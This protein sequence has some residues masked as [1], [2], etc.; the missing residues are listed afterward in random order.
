MG[1]EYVNNME[2]KELFKMKA[3][4]PNLDM[5]IFAR[6]RRHDDILLHQV[7]LR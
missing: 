1:N 7:G 6:V 5:K 3:F 2:N 4:E